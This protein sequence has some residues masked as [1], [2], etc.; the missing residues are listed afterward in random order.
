MTKS[1]ALL[2]LAAYTAVPTPMPSLECIPLKGGGEICLERGSDWGEA[3]MKEPQ[4]CKE[5]KGIRV[6]G[7]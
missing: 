5:I 1:A 7:A 2:L 6:C 3:P 4:Q